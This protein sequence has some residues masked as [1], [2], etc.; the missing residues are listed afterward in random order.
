MKYSLNSNDHKSLKIGFKTVYNNWQARVTE[1][2]VGNYI[3]N[4]LIP[5]LKR[6]GWSEAIYARGWFFQYEDEYERPVAKQVSWN[7]E[8]Q[9]FLIANGLYPTE[10]FLKTFKKLARLP[11]TYS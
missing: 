3:E 10:K 7:K 1:T 6:Q 4:L 11:R 9:R 5:E 2:L 8:V